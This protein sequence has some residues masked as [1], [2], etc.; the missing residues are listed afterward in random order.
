[1]KKLFYFFFVILLTS[2]DSHL[3]QSI[4]TPL[5]IEDL[6]KSIKK[7]SL[8]ESKY[9]EIRAMCDSESVGDIE[10][11][12]FGDITYKDVLNYI[13]FMQDTSYFKPLI[14]EWTLEWKGK[15]GQYY[16]KVDSIIEY[17]EIYE[18]ENSLENYVKLELV[19]IHKEYYSYSG[20]V[21][22][23]NLGFRLTP[24]KGEINQL[25]FTYYIKA[26]I[27][28][29]EET[30]YMSVL[31]KS[32]CLMSQPFANPVTKYWEADYSNEKI[33]K[34]QNIDSFN[35]DYNIHIEVQEIRVDGQNKSKDDL[36]IPKSVQI[37]MHDKFDLFK[38][39]I[40]KELINKDYIDK[41]DYIDQKQNEIINK[42]YPL[43]KELI[44]TRYKR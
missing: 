7:D 29:N 21:R 42:K 37:Y 28:D 16:S 39:D 24:L 20:G 40:V 6:S 19:E 25:I 26:K 4:F 12:K 2:C 35:R 38:D 17:W 5:S 27:N 8:F 13:K 23:V 30:S 32:R 14:E 36:G 18:K 43:I 41:Y 1:M 15:Y 3:N 31:D 9:K 33:L 11:A 34:G 44:N 10:K 22:K